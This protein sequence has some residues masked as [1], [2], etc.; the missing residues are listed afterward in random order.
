LISIFDSDEDLIVWWLKNQALK[1]GVSTVFVSIGS[2]FY[3]KLLSLRDSN[4]E[5]IPIVMKQSENADRISKL[6]DGTDKVSAVIAGTDQ[7]NTY[8]NKN[9]KNKMDITTLK[10]IETPIYKEQE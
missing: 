1:Q 7:V 10:E 9:A 6:I 3:K 5:V 2:D 8:L 4:I